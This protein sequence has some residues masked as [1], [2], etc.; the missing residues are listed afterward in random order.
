MDNHSTIH[1]TRASASVLD[2]DVPLEDDL[3]TLEQRIRRLENAVAALTDTSL[4][5][6][7]LLERVK[8][9]IEPAARS[10]AQGV[11]LE[12]TRALPPGHGEQIPVEACY[13]GWQESLA[14]L[15]HLVE[16]EI[17]DGP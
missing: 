6:A 9:E 10:V 7:R 5:E 13:L 12:G 15:A 16:P 4:I 1:G 11:L 17:P 3:E 14:Q 2:H 8:S